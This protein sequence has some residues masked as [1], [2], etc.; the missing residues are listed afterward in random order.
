MV[1]L[2]AAAAVNEEWKARN[3]GGTKF[4][5]S[6]VKV[7]GPTIEVT[8]RIARD[9]TSPNSQVYKYSI[10]IQRLSDGAI[11]IIE[12]EIENQDPP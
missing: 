11:A 12:P 7:Y 2:A 6:G 9:A 4:P 10:V 8:N 5:F 1:D 3:A